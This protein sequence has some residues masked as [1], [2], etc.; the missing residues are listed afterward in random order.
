MPT[1]PSR[2]TTVRRASG[3]VMFFALAAVLSLPGQA[4]QSRAVS[5]RVYSDAQAARGQRLYR[6]QCVMC[7]G[8]GLEGVVGPP[9]AGAGFLSAW[10][11]RSLADLVD[12]IE[13]TMPPPAAGPRA[14]PPAADPAGR[15]PACPVRRRSIS[16][17]SCSAQA[18][19]RQ[20]RPI[21]SLLY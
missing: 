18:S 19:F 21:S 20:A 8:G 9:L 15:R 7:H 1:F 16:R 5:D 3:I 13:K 11:T 12:K 2:I 10:G 17:R 14:P 6:A 4:G